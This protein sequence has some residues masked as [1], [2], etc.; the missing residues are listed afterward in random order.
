ME[1]KLLTDTME[2]CQGTVAFCPMLAILFV[3]TRMRALQMTNNKGAPQGWAQDGMYLATWSIFLQ[4][5]M[6]IIAGA[7]TGEKAKLD[8]D[9]NVTWHPPN[10]YAFYAVQVIRWFA[11][12]A[13]W[14]GTIT[15]I[16]SVFTITPETAN[17]RGSIPLVTDGTVPVVGD[18]LAGPPPGVQ[19]AVP[20]LEP[21]GAAG[22]VMAPVGETA[23]TVNDANPVA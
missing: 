19:G 14:G 6:V 4:F 7:C 20:G 8:E 22:D 16:V 23:S 10:I 5:C 12:L 21:G 2:S 11:V 13:L 1:W 3:G 15:V 17:G 9:G 18:Q